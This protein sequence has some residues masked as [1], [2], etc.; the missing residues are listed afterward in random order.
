MEYT[1]ETKSFVNK[2]VIIPANSTK[3]DGY[4][5]QL[6]GLPDT[7]NENFWISF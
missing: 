3:F 7:T 2:S 5:K 1:F 6:F 4:S